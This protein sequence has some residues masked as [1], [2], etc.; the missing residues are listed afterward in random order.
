MFL[1]K[2]LWNSYSCV[3]AWKCLYLILLYLIIDQRSVFV[4]LTLLHNFINV[5][6]CALKTKIVFKFAHT[7][8]N[9]CINKLWGNFGTNC[10]LLIWLYILL[11][12]VMSTNDPIKYCCCCFHCYVLL[13]PC[14][15]FSIHYDYQPWS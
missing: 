15:S 4:C 7:A 14:F 1:I 12:Y 8:N 10:K 3:F 2:I 6:L 11:S 5:L 13:F 9:V